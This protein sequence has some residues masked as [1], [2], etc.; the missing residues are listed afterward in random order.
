[1]VY[2]VAVANP[3]RLVGLTDPERDD[4]EFEESG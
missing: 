4:Y 1:V 2:E 3:D